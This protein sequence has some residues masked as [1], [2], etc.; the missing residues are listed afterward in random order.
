MPKTTKAGPS[1]QYELPDEDEQVVERD[2]EQVEVAEQEAEEA[3]PA[4]AAAD[5]RAW[6]RENGLEVSDRGAI[7]AA[8]LEQHAAAHREA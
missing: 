4:P 5:V 6:A 2:V 8:V 1:N 3:A 7:P